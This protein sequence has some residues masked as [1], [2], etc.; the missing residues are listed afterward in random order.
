[1]HIYIT[2][3]KK[4]QRQHKH[5]HT[6]CTR[7][8]QM[9]R[10][11]PHVIFNKI[12]T[13]ALEVITHLRHTH[14]HTQIRTFCHSLTDMSGTCAHICSHHP[15]N[16]ANSSEDKRR[17]THR[18]TAALRG[19]HATHTHTHTHTHTPVVMTLQ[20]PVV[21]KKKERER[22][23][24][25]CCHLCLSVSLSLCQFCQGRAI[26]VNSHSRIRRVTG[27]KKTWGAHEERKEQRRG[28]ATS[29]ST[30]RSERRRLELVK[31]AHCILKSNHPASLGPQFPTFYTIS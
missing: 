21:T 20:S 17:V 22:E 12:R 10:N 29:W 23:T 7:W 31:A 14:T 9:D 16:T 30:R 5:T 2:D 15:V 1:M 26:R 11:V 25:L 6:H 13:T 8:P 19:T 27:N 24:G 4:K 28:V 18:H 3:G